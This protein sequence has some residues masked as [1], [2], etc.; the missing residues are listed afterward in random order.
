MVGY[1]HRP[2]VDTARNIAVHTEAPERRQAG[3]SDPGQAEAAPDDDT[4]PVE[5]RGDGREYQLREE[6]RDRTE[7]D[8]ESRPE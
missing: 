2:P 8:L 5:W 1:E 3:R 4:A 7:L 6:A